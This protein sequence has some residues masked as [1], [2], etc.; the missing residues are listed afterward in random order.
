M[1]FDPKWTPLPTL[2]KFLEEA[3]GFEIKYAP[4]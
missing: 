2:G 1:R 4:K 3:G